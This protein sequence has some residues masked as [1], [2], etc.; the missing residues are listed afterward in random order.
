MNHQL[1]II[2]TLKDRV[3]F[4]FRWMN[5]MNDLKCP[6]Q[7][8]IADGGESKEVE[9][10]LSDKSNYP[11]LIYTY[12]RYPVDI[13][14]IFFYKKFLDVVSRVN[15]PYLL[16]ADNDDFFILKYFQDYINFLEQNT[17]YVTC[18]GE[19]LYLNLL[20]K[21]N[22]LINA[23][24]AD[25]YFAYSYNQSESIDL[26]NSTDR[27]IYFFNNVEREILW[28]SWY[29]ILRTSAVKKS[30]EILAEYQ[31]NE[32]VAFEIHFH[33]SM[34]TLGKY[35]KNK[36][37]FYIRQNGTSQHTN[38]INKQSNLFKRLIENNTFHEILTS[39]EYSCPNL[40]ED[41]KYLILEAYFSWFANSGSY[42]YKSY[43]PTFLSKFRITFDKLDNFFIFYSIRLIKQIIFKILNLNKRSYQRI[44]FIKK[45]I[46]TI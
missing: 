31:F 38:E 45:Y 32:I 18:G 13:D 40:N 10:I 8:L 4:T 12:I 42:L 16:F 29:N 1:T 3:E 44:S 33:I 20:S 35:K 37:P 11:N 24:Y 27:I 19:N 26:E 21:D 2:L 46:K 15:T 25:K 39:I 36:E 7:I 9:E 17:T 5:Y 22:K 14:I 28:C 6:Y 30:F 43:S 41:D 34:L 23:P